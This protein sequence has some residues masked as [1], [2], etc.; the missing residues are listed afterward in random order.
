M[1]D[2]HP[3][4]VDW[5][6]VRRR[7]GA[8]Q[9]AVERGW[10]PTA[11]EKRDL[12]RKRARALAEAVK[13][14]DPG[15]KI[16]IVDFLLAYERY[17]IETS[18]V[19]EVYPLK[20]LTPVPCTPPHV[21]GIVNVRGR[22][23]SIVDLK[24]FFDL[25]DKGLGDLNKVIILESGAMEFGV[26]ADQIAGVRVLPKHSLQRAMPTLTGIREEYLQ[27]ISGD[28]TIVLDGAKILSDP[29]IVVHEEVRV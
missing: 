28:R 15:E 16:E 23:I 26:L 24:K 7:L 5:E 13:K 18:F 14:D 17:G 6:E 8:A 22:I 9:T 11:E 29:K 27:G 4:A 3:R 1:N 2:R 10:S 21:L 12:L 19:R 25:P 20:D